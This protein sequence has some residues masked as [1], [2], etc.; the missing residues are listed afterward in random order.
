VKRTL[1]PCLLALLVALPAP[2]QDAAS[3]SDAERLQGRWK[4][5]LLEE[6]G[7]KNT[8]AIAVVFKGDRAI[9][10]EKDS[11]PSEAVFKV[12]ATKKPKQLDLLVPINPADKIDKGL[13]ILA[14]YELDGDTLRICYR[15]PPPTAKDPT[16]TERPTRFR[17]A[18]GGT[19]LHLH[20]DK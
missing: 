14:I 6:N 1:T 2:G 3:K 9:L 19:L 5:V 13:K 11:P 20:R 12:D 7:K 18:R 15:V 16:V 4:V 8:E 10:E 17:S